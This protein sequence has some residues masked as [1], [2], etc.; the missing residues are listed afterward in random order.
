MNALMNLKPVRN[1]VDGNG[2][3]EHYKTVQV[4]T[5]TLEAL[6]VTVLPFATMFMPLL[7]CCTPQELF[8][9]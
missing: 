9:D 8:L 7:K 2:L 3:R 6:G 5:N 1:P 4:H